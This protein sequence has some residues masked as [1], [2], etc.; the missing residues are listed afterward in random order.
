VT[1]VKSSQVNAL[2]DLIKPDKSCS[3]SPLRYRSLLACRRSLSSLRSLSSCAKTSMR[4]AELPSGTISAM[5]AWMIEMPM[6][7]A[8]R[9]PQLRHCEGAREEMDRV[10]KVRRQEARA[11]EREAG[12]PAR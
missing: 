2:L 7:K 6:K 10:R 3:T 12:A 9:M 11:R 4:G 8:T 1:H 5:A